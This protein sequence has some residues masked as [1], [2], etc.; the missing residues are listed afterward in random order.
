MESVIFGLGRLNIVHIMLRKVSSY[1]HSFCSSDS[2]L[3]GVFRIYSKLCILLTITETITC[4]LLC[5]SV[6]ASVAYECVYDRLYVQ[7]S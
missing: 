4:C 6:K 5:V 1:R 2:V 3:S 7:A